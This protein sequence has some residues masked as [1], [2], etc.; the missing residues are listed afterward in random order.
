VSEVKYVGLDKPD[1]GTVYAPLSRQARNR[2]L[3]LRTASAAATVMPAV[4][5]ALRELDPG[6]PLTGVA[7][8]DELVDTALVKPRSLSILVAAFALVALALSVIGIYGVMTYYVQQHSRDIS[9]RVAL[10]GSSGTVF[11]LVLGQGMTIVA[12]GVAIGAI[13]ALLVTRLLSNLL[14]GVGAADAATYALAAVVLLAVALVACAIPARR[15]VS[16]EP[17]IVLRNE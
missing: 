11:G 16:L 13:A 5:E 10:G 3:I 14:F 4:Q 2:Y 17:A 9:I 6:V 8:I 12:A 7:S 1:E 15:A